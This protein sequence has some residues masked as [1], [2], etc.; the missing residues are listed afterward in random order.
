[1]TE[2]RVYLKIE[3]LQRQFAAYMASPT[4]AR[5]YVPVEGMHS[6]IVEIAPALA[7]HRVIDLALKSVPEVEPGMLY[8]ERQFGI[9]ELHARELA[10]LD[11]AGS[12]ILNGIGAEAR[13]QLRPQVLYS[14][15]VDEVTDRHAVILNRNREASMILPGECLLL[16]EMAPALFA[17]YAANEA[18][19]A[20][21]RLTL[22]DC[23]MIGA[24]GRVFVSGEREDMMRARDAIL[25]TLRDIEGREG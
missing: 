6:L 21:P 12:A 8:T 7:I 23:Q 13:S 22:V 18:E 24:S 1:V 15:I 16:V 3:S 2:L 11:A 10:H 14:E 19:R 17:A 25:A 9:L 4:R 5:G 20:A